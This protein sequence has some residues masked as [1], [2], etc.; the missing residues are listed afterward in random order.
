MMPQAKQDS[1]LSQLG[2]QTSQGV[3]N[4]LWGLDTP[5]AVIA[6]GIDYLQDGQWNNPLDAEERVD[7]EQLL[8]QAGWKKGGTGR[9]LTGMALDIATDPLTYATFGGSALTKAGKTAKALGVLDNAT[10]SASKKLRSSVLDDAVAKAPTTIPSGLD[11]AAV[12]ALTDTLPGRAKR[13]LT[14][15]KTNLRD[16]VD[17][18]TRPLVGKREALRTTTLDDAIKAASPDAQ[19]AIQ[20]QLDAYL[21]KTGQTYDAIKDQPLGKSVGFGIGPASVALD[22]LGSTVGMAAAKGLDRAGEAIRW[23]STGR[24]SH[25][26]FNKATGGQSDP[27]TQAAALRIN[28]AAD[29]GESKGRAEAAEMA[30][31]LRQ[32]VI[33]PSVAQR[34]GIDNVMSAKAG[35]AIDRYIEKNAATAADIDFVENTPGV[36]KFVGRWGY[37]AP[38][39]LKKSE[40]MGLRAHQLDHAYGVGYRPYQMESV[41]DAVRKDQSGKTAMF[42]MVTGDMLARTKS[43]QLPGGL[44]QLRKLSTD[45]RFVGLGDSFNE[46]SI[47]ELLHKEINDPNSAYYHAMAD[48]PVGQAAAAVAAAG[49][50]AKYSKAKARQLAKFL[51]NVEVP[52]TGDIAPVFGNHPAEAVSRYVYGRERAIGTSDEL[53]NTI[54]SRLVNKHRSQVPGGKHIS[55]LSALQKA[56]LK[57]AKNEAGVRGGAAMQ[58]RERISAK[59]AEVGQ[60]IRPDDVDLSMYSLPLDEVTRLTKMHNTFAAPKAVGDIGNA[61]EQYTKMFKA[62][63]LTWPSR[64]TRDLMSGF[65]SNVVEA[66]P[67]AA[68]KGGYHAAKLL[69]GQYDKVAKYIKQIP[70]YSELVD[71]QLPARVT[72]KVLAETDEQLV[73]RFL[74]DAA[75]SGILKD[76]AVLDRGNADRTADALKELIPGFK[77]QSI[78]GSFAGK[79][80]RTYA[81]FAKEATNPFGVKGVLG[82]KETTNPLY[83]TGEALGEWTD[84]VNRLG[85]YMALLHSGAVAS[86]KEA[87]RRMIAAHVDYGSLSEIEKQIR[88]WV[89]FYSYESRILKYALGQMA[90]HPG[91]RYTRMLKIADK[92]QQPDD[93][94]YVSPQ[95]RERSGFMLPKELGEFTEQM[96]LGNVVEPGP[97]L[98]RAVAN[99]DLPGLSALN[100]LSMQKTAGEFDA[101]ASIAS[102]AM[103]LG[104]KLGP[105]PKTAIEF[106][107]QRDMYTKKKLGEAPS[108]IDMMLGAATGN[109]EFRVPTVVQTAAD[110]I[111]PGQGRLLSAGK[112]LSDQRQP[113]QDRVGTTL[114]NTFSPVKILTSDEKRQRSDAMRQLNAEIE[115]YPGATAFETTSIPKE[116]LAQLPPEMQELYALRQALQRKNQQEARAKKDTAKRAARFGL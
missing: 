55:A 4:L 102:T 68:T 24:Y 23:S 2:R 60:S 14:S 70:L 72:G 95:L 52:A 116:E 8:D 77:P 21:K 1:L 62:G 104:Q 76:G 110:L 89:P 91:G 26:L 44:D 109:P 13:T 106:L 94:T 17:H 39:I 48:S 7:S 9:W 31:N 97:G 82:R 53:I 34:T 61:I 19:P 20:Q 43:L 111:L 11:D 101:N 93:E 81:E 69:N 83:K 37:L 59:L 92:A 105:L 54:A 86:P 18:A 27:I 47:T 12:N 73:S 66:G 57:S 87:A 25:A 112:A 35:E 90:D 98:R 56:G 115:R 63:V 75:E 79:E 49:G 36:K 113:F 42:D 107:T 80:G 16:Y 15:L 103:N 71:T 67:A 84:S 28:Q 38:E 114:F 64:Y 45:R 29:A 30:D 58:L 99:I 108:E 6:S 88:A 32:A 65:I 46:D 10:I 40:A 22:P 50:D 5:R 100:T 33:D 85:G 3:S 41:L 96:G 51:N 74:R 78:A